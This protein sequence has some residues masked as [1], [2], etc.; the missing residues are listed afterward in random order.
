MSATLVILAAGQATRYG[1]LK[2]LE[3]FG[4]NGELLMDYAIYDAIN[5]GFDK[6]VVV[7]N[8]EHRQTFT[9]ILDKHILRSKFQL[10]LAVQDKPLGTADALR[11]AAPYVHEPMAVLNSDDYYG[12]G[13][14]FRQAYAY[15]QQL[16]VK[17]TPLRYALLGYPLHATISLHGKV[18]RGICTCDEQGMLTKMV[19]WYGVHFN[20]DHVLYGT[21][22]AGEIIQLDDHATCSMTF[23]LFP[24]EIMKELSNDFLLYSSFSHVPGRAG[25]FMLTSIIEVHRAAERA[26]VQVLPVASPRWCGVT[27]PEDR[28]VVIAR[29]EDLHLAGVYGVLRQE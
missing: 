12:D 18:S 21:N 20:H 29:L 22:S 2:Q 15:L 14:V 8:E 24:P 13:E 5:A 26:T 10:Q 7:I 6:V 3:A 9:D 1:S 27:S 28:D 16:Q 4:P 11:S 23:W 25:E 19:E 17:G